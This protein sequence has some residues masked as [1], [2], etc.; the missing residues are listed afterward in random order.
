[1]SKQ[2]EN[3][4]PLTDAELAEIAENFIMELDEDST[5][6]NASETEDVLEF[7]DSGSEYVPS[8][9]DGEETDTPRPKKIR[10]LPKNRNERNTGNQISIDDSEPG[11]SKNIEPE[12]S[13]QQENENQYRNAFRK[14][15]S[16]SR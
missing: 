1:M 13:E 15:N 2:L 8:D 6:E 4:R 9:D 14:Q 11:Q 5:Q 12:Q 16:E 7:E 3:N 10:L